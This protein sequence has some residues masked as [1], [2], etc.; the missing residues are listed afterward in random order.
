MRRG[1]NGSGGSADFARNGHV[2]MFTAPS[3]AQHGTISTIVP[4]VSQVEH[5]ERDVQVAV[6]EHG[7]ADLRGLSSRQRA[8]LIIEKCSNPDYKPNRAE[9]LP[10]AKPTPICWASRSAGTTLISAA[11]R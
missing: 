10:Y 2:S 7:L 9:R 3:T 8:H 4:M 5:T 11:E 6:S 1:Q